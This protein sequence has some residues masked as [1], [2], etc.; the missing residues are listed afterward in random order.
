MRRTNPSAR[1]LAARLLPL[2]IVLGLSTAR[3]EPEIGAEPFDGLGD[4]APVCLWLP[5]L[6]YPTAL[7]D[8][9]LGGEVLV[10]VYVDETG[11]IYDSE[12]VDSTLPELFI[13]EALKT[14]RLGRFRPARRN[15]R[16][17]R[18]TVLVPLSFTP[19]EPPPVREA[20]APEPEPELVAQ[21]VEEEPEPALAQPAAEQ[22]VAAPSDP[23]V[24]TPDEDEGGELRVLEAGFG[25]GVVSRELLGE[26]EVFGEGERVYFWMRVA[27]ATP[28]QRLRHAWIYQGRVVQEIDLTMKSESWRSWSYK[29]LFPGMTG[30][31][32][33]ELRD[34]DGSLVG[35][36]SFHC[37]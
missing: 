31:W 24:E 20:P 33:L 36:W 5:P 37:E 13:V 35:S 30:A 22:P 16:G 17:V 10:K 11:R 2:L 29:T 7:E 32:L 1:A 15:G 25:K 14:A 28:G 12:L 26:S 8:R 4:G 18:S 9:S 6:Q 3:A 19:Q 23:P 21:P 27:G 34:E